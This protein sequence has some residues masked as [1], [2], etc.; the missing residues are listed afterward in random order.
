MRLPRARIGFSADLGSNYAQ[1]IDK[2]KERRF[3]FNAR[4]NVQHARSS[5]RGKNRKIANPQRQGRA[6]QSL[7]LKE[8]LQGGGALLI[9]LS[10]EMQRKMQI[11]FQYPRGAPRDK[12]RR[13]RV[14][15]FRNLLAGRNRHG[16]GNKQAHT[17]IMPDNR[18]ECETWMQKCCALHGSSRP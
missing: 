1:A 10:K 9:E 16:Q 17:A 15:V 11:F 14:A 4:V 6:V 5:Q 8:V 3:R 12:C 13:E 18:T 2:A 7:S